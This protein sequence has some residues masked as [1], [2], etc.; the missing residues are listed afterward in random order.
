MKIEVNTKFNPGDIA[1]Y[2]AIGGVFKVKVGYINLHVGEDGSIDYRY[3]GF[4]YPL[5]YNHWDW[6][7]D[8]DLYWTRKEAK[9]S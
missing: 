4:T 9:E 2:R 1:Y 3:V 5:K 8:E 6:F 7:R